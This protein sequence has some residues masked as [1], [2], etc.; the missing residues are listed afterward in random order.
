MDMAILPEIRMKVHKISQ[1]MIASMKLEGHMIR[2]FGGADPV[3]N[4]TELEPVT[5][6]GDNKL[7]ALKVESE[8]RED[9]DDNAVT[10]ASDSNN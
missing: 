4:E 8:A 10:E 7:P 1:D 3:H 2:E 6:D 5:N 9:E